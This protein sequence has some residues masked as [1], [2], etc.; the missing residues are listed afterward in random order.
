MDCKEIA[1]LAVCSKCKR[2][3]LLWQP[4]V[5]LFRCGYCR[6]D[7]SVPDAKKLAKLPDEQFKKINEIRLR[8]AV[9]SR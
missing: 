8:V 3:N 2:P 4:W 6:K 9:L 7:Y 5:N 1:D